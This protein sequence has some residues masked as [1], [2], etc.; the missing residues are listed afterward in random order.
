MNEAAEV[1]VNTGLSWSEHG[2]P[3]LVIGALFTALFLLLRMNRDDRSE[4]RKLHKEERKEWQ[5]SNRV[6]NDAMTLVVKELTTA[7][8]DLEKGSK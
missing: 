7:V 8:R 5:E 3:G 6:A 4:T 1:A 2:L